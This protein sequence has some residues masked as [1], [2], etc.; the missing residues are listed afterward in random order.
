MSHGAINRDTRKA[1]VAR[2]LRA[3][4]SNG[5]ISWLPRLLA[6]GMLAGLAH[7]L[8]AQE[9]PRPTLPAYA[10]NDYANPRPLVDALTLGFHGVE[11]DVFLVDG[12]LRVGHDKRTARTGGML[13]SLYLA[14]LRAHVAR[15]GTLTTDGRPFLL[16]IEIKE[17]SSATYDAVRALLAGYRGLLEHSG[18][19]PA[20]S[21]VL[22]GWSPPT[23]PAEGSIDALIGVQ[24]RLV[25]TD[26]RR[27]D[28]L[29]TR[30]HL[31]SL[32]Y[33]K[34]IGRWWRTSG[35]RR[36]WWNAL[37]TARAAAPDR[38]IRVHNVPVDS[39]IYVRLYDAGVD[40]IGTKQ[41]AESERILRSLDKR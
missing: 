8:E 40:L 12:V 30:V 19:D 35:G 34:T 2:F 27:L 33:G 29:G 10:H 1:R 24:Y 38:L 36:Q 31:I 7:R 9:C 39:A 22:V 18:A 16:T 11:A 6:L 14:P 25:R 21:V 37:R 28:T 17:A 41:L 4:H 20:L 3:E 13:D 5:R 26:A 32:D 15:C 23:S